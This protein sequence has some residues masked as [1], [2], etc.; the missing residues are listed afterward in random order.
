MYSRQQQQNGRLFVLLFVCFIL[1]LFPKVFQSYRR[2][3]FLTIVPKEFHQYKTIF[4]CAKLQKHIPGTKNTFVPVF[5]QRNQKPSFINTMCFSMFM[6]FNFK[7]REILMTTYEH[8]RELCNSRQL[9]L[10]TT[11]TQKHCYKDEEL[12][13]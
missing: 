6:F 8:F 4:F 12:Y 11:F 3:S 5:N 2:G 13:F 10:F 9:I 1:R 7:N